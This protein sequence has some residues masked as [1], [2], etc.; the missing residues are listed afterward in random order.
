LDDAG[1]LPFR[2]AAIVNI[3]APF[4][5]YGCGNIGD[6][7][8]LNGFASLLAQ[9][10]M[11][12]QISVG[13]RNP[14]HTARVE[15]AFRYFRTD[16]HDP[17]RWWAKL[18]ASAHV[19]V[20]GTPIMD[21]LGDWPLSELTP[22]VRS[23]DHWRVP[24][25]FVGVGVENLRLGESRRIVAT[26]IAPRVRHWSVRCDRDRQRLVDYGVSPGVI[27]V[28]ADSAWLIEP[29]TAEFGRDYLHRLE[30]DLDSPVVGVNLVNE[31]SM[32]DQHPQMVG[33]LAAALD[34][35][36]CKLNARILFLSNEIRADSSFDKAA[37]LQ[38]I[39]RMTRA[40]RAMLAPNDYL[41]PR[42]MMSIIGC[43]DLTMSMRYHFCLFSVLQGVPFIA[44]ER[45]DKISDLCWDMGWL[46]RIM[47]PRLDPLEIV[48]HGMKL[49]DSASVIKWQLQQSAK[50]MRE[51]SLR[52]TCALAALSESRAN[53]ISH[54]S[55]VSH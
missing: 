20:G 19:V 11:P 39:G 33:A 38:V 51:R 36:A 6:E 3:V 42:E 23:I 54:K 1:N 40:D 34:E 10:G 5:F 17:R 55:L 15:P 7:A 14:A 24:L 22:L 28:A 21:V 53:R 26:E 52:N 12:A 47:P 25:A 48:V 2:E 35:L 27:T 45:S 9:C 50:E 41:S 31:N 49:Y 37:A 29:V 4:G 44:I 46:A 8:T 30:V 32:F 43:C 18:R 13:S 16:C